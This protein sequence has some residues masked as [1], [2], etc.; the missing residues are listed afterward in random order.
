MSLTG[1]RRRQRHL[2]YR[3]RKRWIVTT[4]AFLVARVPELHLPTGCICPDVE[5]GADDIRKG[6]RQGTVYG[7][8]EFPEL[9]WGT[10]AAVLVAAVSC[11]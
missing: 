3:S 2:S 8:R 1:L 11:L 5:S 7:R 10:R 9:S 6:Y 4:L